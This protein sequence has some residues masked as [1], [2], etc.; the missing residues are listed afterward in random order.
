MKAKASV[1]LFLAAGALLC[2]CGGG[3]QPA[4]WQLASARS[5][6]L[7]QR[8]YLGG[9][10]QRADS[11]FILA[12]RELA[13]TG[14]EDLVARAEALDAAAVGTG[15]Y[16]RVV[17]DE[18]AG[19]YRLLRSVDRQK[20]QTYFLFSLTQVQLA[21]AMFPVGHLTKDEVRAHARA[22][23]LAVADKPDSH[24]ICFVPDGDAAA[25]VERRAE[26]PLP[27][28]EVVDTAGRVLGT[29]RG[30]HGLTVGQRKGLGLAAGVPLYVLRLDAEESRVIVGPR[31][32]LASRELTASDVNWISGEAPAEPRRVTA[33]IR[34]RHT[35]APATV[36]STG[37]GRAHVLFDDSQI[38]I[39]PGQAVVFYD[40][41]EVL[42]GGWIEKHGTKALEVP[43]TKALEV[44]GG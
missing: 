17:F 35:D 14:R 22:R 16:A 37:A 20:D 26:S 3:P 39:T 15:H 2:A 10:T 33:R 42:G 12:R 5:M 31:E 36:T 21:R 29:H 34:H 41:E 30:V 6:D 27:E 40:G 25:F 44:P 19:R 1:A 7:F 23:G 8:Y 9:E 11:E 13:S 28:A 18:A 38:A 4:D 32:E 43:G 24:E